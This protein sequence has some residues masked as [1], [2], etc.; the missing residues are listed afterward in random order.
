MAKSNTL[1]EDY[2]L[3]KKM[4]QWRSL[5][6]RTLRSYCFSKCPLL[7]LVLQRVSL[8][9]PPRFGQTI[10]LPWSPFYLSVSS[11]DYTSSECIF[12][13]FTHS[14]PSSSI[15][16]FICRHR[17]PQC[18]AL[19]RIPVQHFLLSTRQLSQKI[20]PYYPFNLS[21]CGAMDILCF[22]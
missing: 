2:N 18:P 6:S 15:H 21:K 5:P 7:E 12:S 13:S 3:C 8:L 1:R 9:H 11:V 17:Y 14:T 20:A 10:W 16:T 22:L 19:F 4:G